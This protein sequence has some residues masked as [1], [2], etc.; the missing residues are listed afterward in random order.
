MK[1]NALWWLDV[2]FEERVQAGA[3]L[4]GWGLG[5]GG[6]PREKIEI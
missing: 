3:P 1:F 4:H 2:K 5:G 6:P